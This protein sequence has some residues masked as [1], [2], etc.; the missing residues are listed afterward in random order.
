MDPGPGAMAKNAD[1]DMSGGEDAT[2]ESGESCVVG[3]ADGVLYVLPPRLVGMAEFF[4]THSRINVA[5]R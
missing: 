1:A 4:S 3:L 2:D 5:L